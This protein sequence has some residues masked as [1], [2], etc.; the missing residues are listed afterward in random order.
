MDNSIYTFTDPWLNV[1]MSVNDEQW[2][3]TNPL[4][5]EYINDN[6][7]TNQCNFLLP[8]KS[9]EIAKKRD[10]QKNKIQNTPLLSKMEKSNCLRID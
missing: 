9:K 4:L 10:L 8:I 5:N 7:L 6:K 3:C 2:A 1:N